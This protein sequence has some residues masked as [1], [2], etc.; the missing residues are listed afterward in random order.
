MAEV[1]ERL[2]F[3]TYATLRA[4]VAKRLVF[5]T[6]AALLAEVVRP[7]VFTTSAAGLAEIVRRG[8]VLSCRGPL[9]PRKGGAT[10]PATLQ[11]LKGCILFLFLNLKGCG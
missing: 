1:M 5:T 6:S 9:A 7:L 10:L 8:E 4:E 11:I 2:V 3:T